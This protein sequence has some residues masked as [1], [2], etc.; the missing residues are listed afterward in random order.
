MSVTYEVHEGDLFIWLGGSGTEYLCKVIYEDQ[1]RV[2]TEIIDY[3]NNAHRQNVAGRAKLNS[4]MAF[5]KKDLRRKS[6]LYDYYNPL[7]K[8]SSLSK[9]I[10]A[11]YEKEKKHGTK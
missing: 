10:S 1:H 2:D 9:L 11:I 5:D 6:D 4:T 3:I 8:R 7:E